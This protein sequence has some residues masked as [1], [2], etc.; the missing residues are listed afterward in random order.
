M[1]DL[2]HSVTLR[3]GRKLKKFYIDGFSGPGMHVEQTT[4]RMIEGSPVGAL[5]IA[6]PFDHYY[7]I[8]QAQPPREKMVRSDE[9]P[10]QPRARRAEAVLLPLS[11]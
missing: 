5:K 4:G 2:R 11:N 9:L 3:V 1:I 7:F 8:D 6:P 10:P